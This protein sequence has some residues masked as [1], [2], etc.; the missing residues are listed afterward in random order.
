MTSRP[1][2]REQKRLAHTPPPQSGD[3]IKVHV[4][5]PKPGRAWQTTTASLS[6]PCHY[7]VYWDLT[8]PDPLDPSAPIGLFN[9]FDV[10]NLA[11]AL[12]RQPGEVPVDPYEEVDLPATPA[13]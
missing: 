1:A 13:I 10:L 4:T 2:R 3:F 5:T 12:N 7:P 6:V 11:D 8:D 9:I